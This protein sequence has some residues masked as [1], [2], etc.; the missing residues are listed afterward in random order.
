[1]P[2][3]LFIKTSSLGDVIHHMP[4]L[5]D[6]RRHFPQAI[7]A[8]VVEEAYA[9]LLRLHPAINEVFAVASR[10]WRHALLSPASWREALAFRRQLR[11]YEYDAVIDSQGLL[12]TGMIAWSAR[13]TRHGYD[14]ASIK[15][16]FASHCYNVRHTVSRE[17]HAIERNRRLSGLALGYAPEPEV[18]YGLDRA[19]LK[20]DAE[21][22]YAVLVHGSAQEKKRWPEDRWVEV[23]RAL[24]E[25]NFDTVLPWGSEQEQAVAA[26]IAKRVPGARVAR[27]GALDSVAKL[28]AGAA[29]VIGVDTGLSHLAAALCVPLVAIFTA[30]EPGLTGPMGQGPIAIVGAKDAPPS[31]KQVI[32]AAARIIPA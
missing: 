21:V 8:W 10:R 15:E 23:G 30:S 5:V 25:R 31:A 3:I 26:R 20:R 18:D 11:A 29:L 28:I 7:I 27:P 13:G 6:A 24:A 9:P 12:R 17:L 14:A 22:P 1:M 19:A 16:T 32:E 2:D 4:A